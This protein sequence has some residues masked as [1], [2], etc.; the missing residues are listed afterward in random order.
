MW[1]LSTEAKGRD[2]HNSSH[3]TMAELNHCFIIIQIISAYNFS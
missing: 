3:H 1:M 2:L